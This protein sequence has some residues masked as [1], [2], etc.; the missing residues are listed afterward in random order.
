MGGW[1]SGRPEAYQKRH[2]TNEYYFLDIGV[3][4][5]G[6][7]LSD[8]LTFQCASGWWGRWEC[9]LL[10]EVGG[11]DLW[12]SH[13]W[14]G[15]EH[16]SE[17]IGIDWTSCHYGGERPYFI[18]PVCKRRARRLYVAHLRE[19]PVTT[20]VGSQ[21]RICLGLAYKTQ[22]AYPPDRAAMKA[23][24]IRRRIGGILSG[25]MNTPFPDKPKGMHWR[26]YYTAY[27]TA[28][29]AEHSYFSY[30]LPMLQAIH[31]RSAAMVDANLRQFP[32]AG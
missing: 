18:C 19:A 8:G 22:S 9:A 1:G 25:G 28:M 11:G 31:A 12:I 17:R 24:R 2:C 27:K 4:N 21:C 13:K 26:T 5:D 29:D 32:R 15:G 20:W 23:K 14:R 3:W 6:R 10:V 7:L 16:P 30:H